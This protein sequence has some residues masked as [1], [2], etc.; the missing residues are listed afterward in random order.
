MRKYKSAKVWR[1]FTDL[2]DYLTLAAVIDNTVFS[3]HG[4]LSPSISSIDQI[5]VL[6]RFRGKQ[7]LNTSRIYFTNQE[8]PH[9]GPLADLMWSDPESARD[10]FRLSPR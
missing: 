6:D 8:I 1:M 3:I 4:G 7:L 2:F 10:E 5:K 9:E